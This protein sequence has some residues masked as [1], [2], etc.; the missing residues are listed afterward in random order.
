MLKEAEQYYL[1]KLKVRYQLI[2]DNTRKTFV[3]AFLSNIKSIRIL[4]DKLLSLYDFKYLFINIQTKSGPFRLV[5]SCFRSSGLIL[6]I[7][8]WY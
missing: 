5:F 7:K 3:L 4:R 2:W 8:I 6:K 1:S